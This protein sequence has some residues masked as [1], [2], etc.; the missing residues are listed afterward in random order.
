M[1][2]GSD[3]MLGDPTLSQG[4]MRRQEVEEER[5]GLKAMGRHRTLGTWIPWVCWPRAYSSFSNFNYDEKDRNRVA[6]GQPGAAEA[7]RA[8]PGC[9]LCGVLGVGVRDGPSGGFDHGQ[10]EC[11]VDCDFGGGD[12]SLPP[13][14]DGN[15]LEASGRETGYDTRLGCRAMGPIGQEGPGTSHAHNDGDDQAG[16]PDAPVGLGQGRAL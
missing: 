13:V 7:P 1:P 6:E 2:Q 9:E 11:L 16:D 4:A 3:Q 5:L 15:S 8:L 10:G 14:P 12:G